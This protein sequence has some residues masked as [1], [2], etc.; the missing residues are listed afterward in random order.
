MK[1]DTA[2][3]PIIEPIANCNCRLTGGCEKCN[4]KPKSF[5]GCISD[6]EADKMKDDIKSEKGR[7]F[8]C[9]V[10]KS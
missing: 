5:I 8:V 10:V 6:K 7:D 1:Y 2:G 3:K 9:S 4:P